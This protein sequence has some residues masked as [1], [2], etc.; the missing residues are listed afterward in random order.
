MTDKAL[1][2]E[3]TMK[4]W[5]AA[6]LEVSAPQAP[7]N[8]PA[9]EN[10]G[11]S[12]GEAVGSQEELRKAN[13]QLEEAEKASAQAEKEFKTITEEEQQA[14]RKYGEADSEA[15]AAGVEAVIG[16]GGGALANIGGEI[17]D[18]LTDSKKIGENAKKDKLEGR[19]T[20]KS[21]G[22]DDDMTSVKS[23]SKLGAGVYEY[24]SSD[25][26]GFKV[27]KPKTAKQVAAADKAKKKAEKGAFDGLKPGQSAMRRD[28]FNQEKRLQL[29]NARL[30]EVGLGKQANAQNAAASVLGAQE[31][32]MAQH[33]AAKRRQLEN[34]TL[35]H[36]KNPFFV[37]PNAMDTLSP[38]Y[39]PHNNSRKKDDG[40]KE[41]CFF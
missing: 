19:K 21:S 9:V 25:A 10:T 14:M 26:K 36:S 16:G 31:H 11:P 39:H 3:Q 33:Q 2:I 28:T 27:S 34:G 24:L 40:D 4:D 38:Q 18:S 41:S 30:A 32:V 12:H 35:D 7:T 6:A 22:D 20:K 17:F 8:T 23:L 29:L 15:S 5:S 13:I 37:N 1:K